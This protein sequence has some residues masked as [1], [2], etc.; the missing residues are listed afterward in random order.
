MKKDD[1]YNTQSYKQLKQISD[2]ALLEESS[3]LKLIFKGIIVVFILL[4]A[5]FVWAA[6]VTINET[7][8]TFGELAPKGNVQILQ[9]LEGGIVSKVLVKSGDVVKKGQLLVQLAFTGQSAELSQLR[10]KEVSLIL[11]SSRINAFLNN[12]PADIIE[13]GNRVVQS[14]YNPVQQKA[15]IATF[16]QDQQRLL[17]QQY[18]TLRSQAASLKNTIAQREE[19]L[20]E[21]H[22][23]KIIW[24]KHIDLLRQEFGMYQKLKKDNYVSRK[25][26]LTVLRAVNKAKGDGV[27]IDSEIEQTEESIDESKNK[28]AEVASNAREEAL[29][30]LSKINS[31]LLDVRHRIEKS[32]ARIERTNVKAPVAGTVKGLDVAPGNV[33]KPGGTL[34][35]IVPEGGELLA[36][37]KILPR[38]V[39]HIKIGDEVSVK[40]LTYDYARYGSIKGKL[41][42][43]SASTFDD[44]EGK[45]Y[46][47]A[48][49]ELEK[50]YIGSKRNPRRLRAGMTV[51]A[52]IITGEKT[53]LQYLLKPIHRS[54]SESFTER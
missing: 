43:I 54:V 30:E 44:T 37:S 25:D 10:S 15:Q 51:Q 49:I 47:K 3:H 40:V 26:Y 21:L 33:I 18:A 13:W 1:K 11:N 41:T 27:R 24:K 45:P 5:F 23:Q 29:E 22:Q 31:E 46:Y 53:L 8:T 42:S 4:V 36:E 12:Q 2:A 19:K 52:D 34:L 7:S 14:K 39:G 32:T 9:H 16:L 48:K 35:E 17:Q 20:K 50:Q 38:E 6:F 28:L